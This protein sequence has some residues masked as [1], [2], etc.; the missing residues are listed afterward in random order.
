MKRMLVIAGDRAL[1]RF[2]AEA[3]LERSLQN[4][5]PRPNDPW[6]IARAHNGLEAFMLVTRGGRPFDVIVVDQG[7]PDQDPL[8][9][10]EKLRKNDS[11]DGVPVF[12]MTERGRDHHS[13]RIASE[14][15][16][17]A[18]FIE[19]PV[20]ADS[21][22]AALGNLERKRRVLLVEGNAELAERYRGALSDAGY[23]TE[24]VSR[25]RDALDRAPRFRPDVVIT[26]LN[27]EDMRGADVCIELKRGRLDMPVMLYGN[28]AS[29]ASQEISENAHR[30]DDFVQAPFDDGVLI[31]RVGTLIGR[32]VAQLTKKKPRSASQSRAPIIPVTSQTIERPIELMSTAVKSTQEYHSELG[33]DVPPAPPPPSAS[34]KAVGPTKRSTRR[35]PCHISMSI[36]NGE[37]VYT[38]KTLDISH[39]GIFLAT[40]EPLEIGTLIDMTFQIPN[41]PRVVNAVGKVAWAEKAPEAISATGRAGIG[42]KF[43]KIDPTDLQLIVD[44]VNR[45]A[46][47]VYS[48]S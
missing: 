44:Y 18:G 34:P 4:G 24:L 2:V 42:V 26:A 25:G 9:L 45:V 31:E 1:T 16:S 11:S 41:S 38:S 47:V 29:L 46:R 8:E 40:D 30:A 3:L 33:E 19:K 21:L 7:L 20:S 15:Y 6:D 17:V 5:A 39:G 14:H 37:R 22:R 48:A 35:V 13:R 28:V 36:R 27:L 32:G 12:V 43:S 23:L 10:L